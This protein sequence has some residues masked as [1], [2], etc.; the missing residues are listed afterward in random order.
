MKTPRQRIV[1]CVRLLSVLGGLLVPLGPMF[2]ADRAEQKSLPTAL[3]EYVA[4][5]D[6][7]FAWSVRESSELP[8]G[9]GKLH[10]IELTSQ[11]WQGITWKHL[12]AVFEPQ[13]LLHDD[14]ALLF[15][16]GGRT[17]SEL[18]EGDLKMG[19]ELARMTK[20]RCAFLLQV[21]NQPLL[22]DRYEDDL[23]SETFLKYIETRD[24]TWP[25]LFPMVKSAVRAMDTLAAFTRQSTGKPVEHFVV[26][27][28]SKR[29]WTTW[30]TAVADRR[31]RGIAPMV[32]DTLNLPKQT[33]Y[34]IDVWGDYSEQIIDYT[35]K[36]L[37]DVLEDKPELPLWKWVDPY[38]YRS[39]LNL[40]K[41]L[42]NGTNDPYWVLDA[43]NNY[44]SDL[45][46]QKYILYVPNAGHGLDGGREHA[47]RTLAAFTAHIASGTPF[48]EIKWQHSNGNKN[49]NLEVSSSAVPQKALLWTAHAEGRDFRKS[50][51]KSTSLAANEKGVFRGSVPRAESGH[52]ALFAEVHFEYRGI[53]YS[54]CTQLATDY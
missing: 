30:L 41:L 24:A 5:E 12:L 42:I 18:R 31:V 27:G 2:A 34:Q 53:P 49:L 6:A 25:L 21:P 43:L 29:G 4:I 20:A 47:L 9:M 45:N 32:I 7:A 37:V 26:T 3:Q 10:Q 11:Q 36:G 19:A 46:G 13:T 23:I 28:A 51:W 8:N 48:P 35:S 1:S 17:G 33:R 52:V 40:P 22:G 54:F 15:I 50:T 39:E 14:Q 38:T 44:W 16:T